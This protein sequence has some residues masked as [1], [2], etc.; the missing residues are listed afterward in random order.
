[1][2]L[3]QSPRLAGRDERGARSPAQ[4]A[5]QRTLAS[6][7]LQIRQ[8]G[9]ALG[10]PLLMPEEISHLHS[11]TASVRLSPCSELDVSPPTHVLKCPPPP[12]DGA[13]GR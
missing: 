12:G 1:M 5:H 9:S 4:A 10:G 13:C 3:F 8:T 7:P 11:G 6:P 2:W